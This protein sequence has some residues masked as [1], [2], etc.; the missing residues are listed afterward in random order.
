MVV[1]VLDDFFHPVH[2]VQ[3]SMAVEVA[4]V[5]R[6]TKSIL[7]KV[8]RLWLVQVPDHCCVGFGTNFSDFSNIAKLSCIRVHNLAGMENVSLLYTGNIEFYV[9]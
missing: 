3:A 7:I 8:G 4:K 9:S 5:S 1:A 6:L 2:I